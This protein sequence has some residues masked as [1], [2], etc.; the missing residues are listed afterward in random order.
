VV[1][2]SS[3]EI[4]IHIAVHSKRTMI[5]MMVQMAFVMLHTREVCYLLTSGFHNVFLFTAST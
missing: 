2:D 5:K 4:A 3:D 1:P